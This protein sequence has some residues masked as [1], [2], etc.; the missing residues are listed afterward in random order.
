MD[1]QIT[2]SSCYFQYDEHE[3]GA[4]AAGSGRRTSPDLAKQLSGARKDDWTSLHTL[5]GAFPS[6]RWTTYGDVTTVIGSHAVPVGTRLATF[7]RCPNT[8][9][10]LTATEGAGFRWADPTRTLEENLPLWP[11]LGSLQ[12]EWS[13]VAVFTR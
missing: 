10:V 13:P 3:G 1:C 9:R 11:A 12:G 4:G 6:G 8:W 2:V 5:L 7:S